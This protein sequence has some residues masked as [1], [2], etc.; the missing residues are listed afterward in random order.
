MD[1]IKVKDHEEL[2]SVAAKIVIEKVKKN[3]NATIGFAT[4]GTPLGTYKKMI[5]DHRQN[6][7]S[8]RNIRSFNLDEYVGLTPEN[9]NSY[10]FY[11]EKNLFSHIDIQK[12]NIH[13]PDGTKIDLERECTNYETS[14]KRFGG[15]DLQILGIGRNGHIG[16]NEPGTPFDSQTHIVELTPSTRQA[17]ARYFM[18]INDVPTHALTMGIATILKSKEILLLAFGEEKT[19]AIHR[20]MTG[21]IDEKFPA[22]VLQKH[23]KVTIVADSKA[24][25][26][27]IASA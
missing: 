26:E 23:P 12:S 13:F 8:Y 14:I 2:N 18:S 11:M 24:L 1:I 6:K 27:V 20:L 22:S 7:T 9:P 17:N 16:F 4:G 3:P 15:I 5:E 25:S 21:D 19:E 10:R